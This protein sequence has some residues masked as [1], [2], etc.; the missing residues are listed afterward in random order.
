MMRSCLY[1]GSQGG[2]DALSRMSVIDPM[3][4]KAPNAELLA[5]LQR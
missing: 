2:G 4:A 3:K 1:V 5:N